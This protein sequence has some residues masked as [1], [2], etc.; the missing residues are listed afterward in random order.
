[1]KY[2][3]LRIRLKIDGCQNQ[4]T[5]HLE[6]ESLVGQRQYHQLG[7]LTDLASL[8]VPPAAPHGHHAAYPPSFHQERVSRPN[9]LS[10]PRV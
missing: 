8:H 2:S 6:I 5:G 9:Q 3:M 10:R 4:N 1:M 7:I